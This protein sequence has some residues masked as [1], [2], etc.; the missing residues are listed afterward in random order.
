MALPEKDIRIQ[1]LSPSTVVLAADI[2]DP[3]RMSALG[4]FLHEKMD[5]VALTNTTFELIFDGENFKDWNEALFKEIKKIIH[6]EE[7]VVYFW[8]M[9]RPK[10][11]PYRQ[12]FRTKLG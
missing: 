6:L 1:R 2:E 7:D 3:N 4:T 8:D 11:E 5:A 10:G 12:L 9:T